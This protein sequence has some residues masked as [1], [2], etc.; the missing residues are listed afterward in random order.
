MMTYKKPPAPAAADFKKA[1]LNSMRAYNLISYLYL[2]LQPSIT[3]SKIHIGMW[4]KG[5]TQ[6]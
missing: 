1:L 5:V 3:Q 2:R 6:R 4:Y